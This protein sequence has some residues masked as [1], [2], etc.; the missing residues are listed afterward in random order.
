M[1]DKRLPCP[2]EKVLDILNGEE[3]LVLKTDKNEVVYAICK[4]Y[5]LCSEDFF[6]L[7]VKKFPDCEIKPN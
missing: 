5:I 2:V 3:I 4:D 1:Q 7:I 6:D